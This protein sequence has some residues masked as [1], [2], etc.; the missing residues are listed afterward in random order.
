[1]DDN[2]YDGYQNTSGSGNGT[3][4]YSQNDGSS[5]GGDSYQSSYSSGYNTNGG[6]AAGGSGNHNHNKKNGR[7]GKVAFAIA[8]AAVFG[9]CA[10]AGAYGISRVS[11]NKTT[12]SVAEASTEG[13][14]EGATLSIA[15]GN[16]SSSS[17]TESS[18]A[19]SST[20]SA[21]EDSTTGS[22]ASLGLQTS[23]AEAQENTVTK[24]VAKD[25]P[26]IV[27]V[28]NNYTSTSQD[29]FGQ[30]YS[31]EQTATGSGIIIGKTDDELLIVTN[32][33]VVADE[34]SLQVQ[35]VDESTADANIKG[36][37]SDMDLAVIAVKLADLSDDTKNA[38]AIATLG[39]SDNLKVGQSVIAI[40]NALGYGQSVTTGVVSALNREIADSENGTTNKFIQTDAAI[41]PGNS[42]GALIDLNGNVIGINSSK[43]GA[44][45]V[46]GMCY[47]IPISDAI[48]VIETLMNQ[49]TKTKVSDEDKGYL[50]I[51]GVSVT[52]QVASA[53]N[54]PE[55]VYVASVMDGSGA[56]DAGLQKGDIIT[57]ING[58]SVSDMEDLQD[59]LRYYAAGTEVTLT[60]QR[61][62]SDGKY[63]EQEL[64]VTL[65][66]SSVVSSSNGTEDS[67]SSSGQNSQS[68]SS[69]QGQYYY[70]FPWNQ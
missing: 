29:F 57:K 55:G 14:S 70:S 30:T 60:I 58:S 12:A 35:F 3:Y 16:S 26:S 46:E 41:N 59:Q 65:S 31:Q 68:G 44:T 4:Q 21:S 39:N 69:S 18:A 22:S 48:P 24:I 13:Q 25:M 40:G 66:D 8:L 53:Y 63:A 5:N 42:G 20:E 11:G 15:E 52:S 1:M 54:M 23:D 61:N 67:G 45:T 33:H 9:I 2:R 32:N 38:I 6:G 47:A 56:A 43:I 27:A 64:K 37:D 51:Q 49:S 7:G 34:D 17:D 62:G 50:G 28:Y 10:G 36:T 19:A